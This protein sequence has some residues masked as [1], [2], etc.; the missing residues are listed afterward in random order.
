MNILVLGATGQIGY[1]ATNALART[2]HKVSVLARNGSRLRYPDNVTVIER[3][4]LTP[5]AFKVALQGVDHAIYC[6]GLPEQFLFDTSVFEEVHCELLETFLDALASSSVRRLT[7]LSTYE[8]FEVIDGAISETHPIADTSHMTPYSRSKVRAYRL[9]TDFARAH[10]VHLTTIHPAAVYGGLNTGRGI[11]DYMT[12]LAMWKWHRLPSINAGD[13]PV[14]HVDSLSEVIVKSLDQPGAYIASDQM[15]T[16]R[17]IADAMRRQAPSYVPMVIPKG[18]ARLSASLLEA[19]AKVVRV[20]PLISVGQMHFLTRGWRPDPANAI[21]KLGW[22]PMTLDEGIR[23]FLLKAAP[24][25]SD[26]AEASRPDP[27]V[28]ARLEA[29]E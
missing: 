11:T 6:I 16:L 29:A 2:G 9:V 3:P 13:F 18:L 12:N 27:K 22:T 15:T 14:I 17:G 7:Y 21:E 25:G 24:A 28:A 5:E 10:A 23:R 1:A 26:H 20:K 19:L 8:V 4:Q